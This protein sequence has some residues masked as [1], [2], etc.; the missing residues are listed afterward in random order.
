MA[1]AIS[2]ASILPSSY[3]AF[4]MQREHNSKS[5]AFWLQWCGV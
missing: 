5:K 1:H 4:W 3:S 2:I